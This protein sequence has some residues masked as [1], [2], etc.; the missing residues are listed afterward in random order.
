MSP[1]PAEA[2]LLDLVSEGHDLLSREREILFDGRFEGLEPI[3]A[4]KARL[5]EQL[6]DAIPRVRGTRALR[7]ALDGLIADSR[8][9]ER[10][11]GAALGGMRTARRSIEAIVAT[12]MGDVAYAADG[13][14]ITSRAD[15]VRKSSR[16]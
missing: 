9:N 6:E 3:G 5:L 13:T 16:A 4:E 7:T 8:R 11:I 2:R 1:H 15:A 14:R 10:L 12:R